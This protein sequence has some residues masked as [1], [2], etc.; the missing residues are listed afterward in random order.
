MLA[1]VEPLT[2]IPNEET[3][4]EAKTSI[5]DP[6]AITSGLKELIPEGH[7]PDDVPKVVF[8][9]QPD[10][11][12][13]E[14]EGNGMGQDNAEFTVGTPDPAL[15]SIPVA[16]SGQKAEE[17]PE[18]TAVVEQEG[19]RGLMDY[20]SQTE[21]DSCLGMETDTGSV[22]HSTLAQALY[23]QKPLTNISCPSDSS[24]ESSTPLQPEVPGPAPLTSSSSLII[25]QCF[26]ETN[27]THLSPGHPTVVFNQDQISSILR[28]V[29]DESARA[30]FEML[31]SVVVRASRLSLHSPTGA[32]SRG[33]S[34]TVMDPETDTD[35]GSESVMTCNTREGDSS[36]VFTSDAESRRDLQSSVSFP[37]P[38]SGDREGQTDQVPTQLSLN[39]PSPERETLAS[40][41][42]EAI[43][44]KGKT[45][46]P[47]LTASKSKG[48]KRPRRKIGRVM[49]EEYFDSMPWTRVF[50]T[51]P[52]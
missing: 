29:A 19:D 28:I 46:R 8:L 24:N 11:V 38:T 2:T 10:S 3:P 50:V 51:G 9:D 7:E 43:R 36:P 20:R 6:V 18:T 14:P 33:R 32:T 41:R 16:Q 13:G 37:I 26:E 31:N 30:S 5:S 12:V 34:R 35:I 48:P 49:K 52:P 27:P 47:T 40:L 15:A 25:K 42:Q 21:D 1:S 44:E 22:A 4:G 39:C 45:K 23:C 17:G